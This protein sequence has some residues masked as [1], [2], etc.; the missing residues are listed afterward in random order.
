MTMPRPPPRA[1][2]P[3]ASRIRVW[4]AVEQIVQSG[5]RPTVE[6]VRE[7]LGGGSPNSVTAYINEWYQ[8]LGSRLSTADAPA[9]GMPR[10]ALTLLT[11]LW[12]VAATTRAGQEASGPVAE[13]RN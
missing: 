6:G 1:K 2:E 11:E 7:R 8:E 13:L 4:Q 9:L 12:R 10:E 5:R 3:R